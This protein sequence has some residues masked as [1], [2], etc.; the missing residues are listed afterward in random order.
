MWLRD[1]DRFFQSLLI[2]EHQICVTCKWKKMTSNFCALSAAALSTLLLHDVLL[3]HPD[4][5]TVSCLEMLQR[6]HEM[7]LQSGSFVSMKLDSWNKN[8]LLPCGAW[9]RFFL[10]RRAAIQWQIQT[11]R[12]RS[13]QRAALTPCLT[14]DINLYPAASSVNLGHLLM[15]VRLHNRLC[16]PKGWGTAVSAVCETGV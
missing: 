12:G 1:A 9:R 11:D 2:T 5:Q 15:C 8:L 7:L 3:F 13:E 16:Q 6:S 10:R 4:K 14:V